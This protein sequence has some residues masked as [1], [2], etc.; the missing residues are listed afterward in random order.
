MKDGSALTLLKFHPEA[1]G[2]PE[3]SVYL[4]DNYIQAVQSYKN[5]RSVYK[6]NRP[7]QLMLDILSKQRVGAE[8]LRQAI[9]A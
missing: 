2:G 1:R 6:D 9:G 7:S 5:S 3:D 4:F 8:P